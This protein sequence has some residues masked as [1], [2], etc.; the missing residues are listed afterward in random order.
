MLA[1]MTHFQRKLVLIEH[2]YLKSV[3]N[4]NLCEHHGYNIMAEYDERRPGNRY[5]YAI[6]CFKLLKGPETLK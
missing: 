4:L 3:L 1:S 5:E 6:S 2:F